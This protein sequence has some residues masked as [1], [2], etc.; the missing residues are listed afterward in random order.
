MTGIAISGYL[1]NEYTYTKGIQRYRNQMN[2]C[3]RGK[4]TGK[5]SVG[6]GRCNENVYQTNSARRQIR[7]R[8]IY[9]VSAESTVSHDMKCEFT[10]K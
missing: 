8:H 10:H 3:E 5:E 2:E 1:M 9:C 7:M 6:I 4:E